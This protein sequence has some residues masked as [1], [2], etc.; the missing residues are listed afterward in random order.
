M[1]KAIMLELPEFLIERAEHTAEQVGRPIETILTEWLEIGASSSTTNLIPI[2]TPYGNE[3][4]AT[5][6]QKFLDSESADGKAE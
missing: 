2:Y 3:H 6:L 1:T 4:I 5:A